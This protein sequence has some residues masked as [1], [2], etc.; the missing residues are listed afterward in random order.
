MKHKTGEAY[1]DYVRGQLDRDGYQS[2][3]AMVRASE[4]G[5]P[6]RRPKICAYRGTQGEPAGDEPVRKASRR[7]QIVFAAAGT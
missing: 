1:S 2:W 5:V 4:F 7:T 3:S 6:Q